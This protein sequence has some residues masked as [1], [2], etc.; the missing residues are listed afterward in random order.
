MKSQSKRIK[1]GKKYTT[2]S[3]P[4]T[5]TRKEKYTLIGGI[6]KLRV[7]SVRCRCVVSQESSVRSCVSKI[8]A[9]LHTEST[10]FTFLLFMTVGKK[11]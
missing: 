8:K 11:E 2:Q 7:T 10:L 1:H 3:T 4:E 6:K 5:E 9:T